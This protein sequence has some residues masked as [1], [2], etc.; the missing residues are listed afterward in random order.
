LFKVNA[1]LPVFEFQL[2]RHSVKSVV[3]GVIF[4]PV[5]FVGPGGLTKEDHIAGAAQCVASAADRLGHV[6]PVRL[7]GGQGGCPDPRRKRTGLAMPVP[8]RLATQI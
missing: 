8:N 6:L 7:G 4:V 1:L 5:V 2:H 3:F